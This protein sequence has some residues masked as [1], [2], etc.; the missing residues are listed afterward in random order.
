MPTQASTFW[1][2]KRGNTAADYE[3]AFAMEPASGRFAVA[4]GATESSF[5]GQWARRLADAYVESPLRHAR[6]WNEWLP[7]VQ[8]RWLA[9]VE[10]RD[11]PW[12]AEFKFEQ[13]AFATFL[14]LVLESSGRQ[15]WHAVAIGDSCLFQVRDGKLFDLFPLSSSDEF[16]NQPPLL[17]SRS[18]A[19][20]ARRA[21]V[22]G[23]GSWRDADRF[24]LATDALAQWFLRQVEAGGMPWELLDDLFAAPD[25]QARGAEWIDELRDRHET[26][27]RVIA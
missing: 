21:E 16:G 26:L 20:D 8:A 11:L 5:A 9:D 22:R 12:Y 10:G 3:D 6:R 18:I 19:A 4:D 27:I 13:G 14:G 25:I 15:P 24:F 7:R 17:G 1:L 2:P 23:H